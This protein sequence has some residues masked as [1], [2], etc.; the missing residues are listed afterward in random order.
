M[1]PEFET[2]TS[3]KYLQEVIKALQEPIGILGGWAIFLHVNKNFQKAQG[4]PYLG[5]RDID[6][7]FHLSKNSTREEMKNSALA[8]SLEILQKKLHFKPVSFRLLR[9]VHT[10]TEEEIGEGKIIPAHFVFPLYV[11]VVVDTIPPKF[12]EVFHF[13]PVD[14]PLLRFAFEEQKYRDEL[15]EFGKKIWLPKPELL[16]ATKINALKQRDKAHKRIKDICDIFAL[17]WYSKEK[18]EVLKEE[19]TQFVAPQ[20][21]STTIRTITDDDYQKASDQLNHTAQEIRRVLELL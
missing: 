9:E 12:K 5:S 21:V 3:Y 10:E 1:Y 20:A 15:E 2:R 19:V 16:L 11:D 6:L 18:P 13:Q 4:R 8:Q 17:L 7:G 14:E